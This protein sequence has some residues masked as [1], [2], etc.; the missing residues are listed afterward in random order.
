MKFCL[1]ALTEEKLEVKIV[2]ASSV[3]KKEKESDAFQ[4]Y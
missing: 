3:Q 1:Q 2:D 4:V